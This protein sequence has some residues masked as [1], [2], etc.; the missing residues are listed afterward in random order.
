MASDHPVMALVQ[1]VIAEDL[2]KFTTLV[3]TDHEALQA[4]RVGGDIPP[5]ARLVVMSDLVQPITVVDRLALHAARAGKQIRT[6]CTSTAIGR[7]IALEVARTLNPAMAGERVLHIAVPPDQWQPAL[8][9]FEGLVDTARSTVPPSPGSEA[10]ATEPPPFDTSPAEVAR[11]IILRFGASLL[12]VAP[13]QQSHQGS[14]ASDQTVYST[15]YALGDNGIWHAGGDPWARWLIEIAELMILETGP[16]GLRGRAL[17]S[18]TAAIDRIKRPGM[19]DQVRP[20]LRAVLDLLRRD[21][22]RCHDVSECAAEDLNANQRY[23]GTMSGVVDL[24]AGSLLSPEEG[25]RALVTIMAPT[26]FDPAARHPIVDD[27]LG[28]MPLEQRRHFMGALGNGIRTIPKR[29]YAVVC[30]PD[31]GKTTYHNLIVNTLGPV[32]AKTAGVNI[33]QDR[34]HAMTNDTQLTPGLTAWW[35]PTRIIIMDE[36]KE[37]SLSPELVKD[38]AGGGKLTARGLRQDLQTKPVTATTFM[39]S[40]EETVPRLR[41][42]DSGLRARYREL[43]LPHIPD[44]ERDEGYIRNE[45]TQLPEVRTAF[46]AA[47]VAAAKEHPEPPVDTPAVRENTTKRVE[48]DAGEL[49]RLARRLVRDGRARFSFAELWAAWCFANSENTDARAPGGIGKRTLVRRLQAYVPDLPTPATV[50]IDKRNVR[51]FRGWQLQSIEE[52]ERVAAVEQALDELQRAAREW[53]N[54]QIEKV[55]SLLDKLTDGDFIEY[56]DSEYVAAPGYSYMQS[57]TKPSAAFLLAYERAR[58]ARRVGPQYTGHI[59]KEIAILLAEKYLVQADWGSLGKLGTEDD[60]AFEA[61]RRMTEAISAAS[62]KFSLAA[63]LIADEIQRIIL[64]LSK[65]HIDDAK[66]DDADAGATIEQEELF[67]DS[68]TDLSQPASSD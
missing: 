48:Q 56:E 38:L 11:R 5:D 35:S 3:V 28:R 32:Y 12:V 51:G 62:G 63:K 15:G 50:K 42:D 57:K 65:D 64:W 49:G 8:H 4:R 55:I 36:V 43:R 18:T 40:N 54:D 14:T 53:D 10:T 22:E 67:D 13:P 41:L 25:R 27:L 44:N 60:L 46:L 37:T 30:E 19:V 2:E 59:E 39:L 33:I 66:P 31:C 23:L 26:E 6:W 21:G 34:R 7:R 47:L 58:L 24:A 29:L 16:A 45:G 9:P 68:K 52:M 17:I 20:M 1:E 61:S